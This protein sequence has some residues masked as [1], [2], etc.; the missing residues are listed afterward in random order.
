MAKQLGEVYLKL[1]VKGGQ[2]AVQQ[3]DKVE[4]KVEKLGRTGEEAG[5]RMQ[6]AFKALAALPAAI[7][8]GVFIVQ[9][10]NLLGYAEQIR[11][12]IARL[13][14]NLEAK[15]A[16][17]F[18]VVQMGKV[19][20]ELERQ[21]KIFS[22]R[23]IMEG[24]AHAVG[25]GSDWNNVLRDMGLLLDVAV[26]NQMSLVSVAENYSKAMVGN[27][28]GLKQ[29]FRELEGMTTEELMQVDVRE[30]LLEA[31]GIAI[32][33]GR[34]ETALVRQMA[35]QYGNLQESMGQVVAVGMVPMLEITTPL[36]AKFAKWPPILV[37]LI[38]GIKTLTPMIVGLAMA[39]H[40]LHL[41]IPGLNIIAAVV[42]LIALGVFA[43]AGW[44]ASVRETIDVNER[45][46]AGFEKMK[47]EIEK[48]NWGPAE[49]KAK[50]EELNEAL[51]RTNQALKEEKELLKTAPA[52][53][54]IVLPLVY[55]TEY[56]TRSTVEELRG[57]EKINKLTEYR[58]QL[59]GELAALD[60]GRL[61]ADGEHA[62]A[63]DMELQLIEIRVKKG[64]I[65]LDQARDEVQALLG[66]CETEQDRLKIE[67]KLLELRDRIGLQRQKEIS[68]SENLRLMEARLL[69]QGT[70]RFQNEVQILAQ[71]AEERRERGATI[72]LMQI[73]LQLHE[74]V[75][76]NAE[77]RLAVERQAREEAK[78][79]TEVVEGW[80][81]ASEAAAD[82]GARFRESIGLMAREDK[83]R[84]LSE[85][86]FELTWMRPE[87]A[88][89]LEQIAG[90]AEA[91]AVIDPAGAE[92]IAGLVQEWLVTLQE[93]PP[94]L[95][96]VMMAADRLAASFEQA[97]VE[98]FREGKLSLKTFERAFEM[99]ISH[100][101]ATI[102][103]RAM[104]FGLLSMLIPGSSA[105]WGK[106]GLAGKIFGF[107]YGGY[108]GPGRPE[109]IKGVIHSE[110]V[111]VPLRHP[112]RAQQLMDLIAGKLGMKDIVGPI[113]TIGPIGGA[114]GTGR[115]EA[116]VRALRRAI[117][118]QG[119]PQVVLHGNLEM[120]WDGIRF[121][122]EEAQVQARGREL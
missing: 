86:I 13:R 69:D 77:A 90:F 42:T 88:G 15:G 109:E 99:T 14:A 54:S 97:F 12:T 47:T 23:E 91:L 95:Q 39:L 36:M 46:S 98:V 4:Q 57:Q 87:G 32:E 64:G 35:I 111:A 116:E 24:M 8:I 9:I 84:R 20:D 101:A 71:I 80:R 2:V 62:K 76:Q 92:R 18:V 60:V 117:E 34:E 51:E 27:A 44:R 31:Q 58:A 119:P 122:I 28:E 43:W 106:G 37:A 63:L 81:E 94:E 26:K 79:Y 75:R 61:K 73:L 104:I 19:A 41:S 53:P 52:K 85:A 82:F 5:S 96:V 74:K 89:A 118:R 33:R 11:G 7:G 107:Q 38:A 103:S 113:P 78:A 40:F 70:G 112:A 25:T 105:F 49:L 66:A 102:A 1:S 16:P 115:V 65:T 29:L 110:E 22:A 67:V 100:M 68:Y 59:E 72:G 10:R 50:Q 93:M 17:P 30:K 55:R 121:R 6:G 3:V 120:T 108:T 48:G 45:M 114:G 21:T 56:E 83:L